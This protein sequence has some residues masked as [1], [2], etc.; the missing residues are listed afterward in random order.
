VCDKLLLALVGKLGES[1]H[2]LDHGFM[3]IS[4]S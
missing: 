3:R 2:H 1:S 4:E